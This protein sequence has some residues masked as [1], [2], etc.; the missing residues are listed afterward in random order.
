M[1]DL[2]GFL[3]NEDLTDPTWKQALKVVHNNLPRPSIIWRLIQS[4]WSG[5]LAS[6]SEFMK[7]L[8][9]SAL[10]M[11]ALLRA[12]E[13]EQPD[14][15]AVAEDV[16]QAVNFLGP[17]YAVIVLAINHT[18]MSILHSK[19][20]PVWR[21]VFRDMMTDVELGYKLGARTSELGLESGMLIGFAH[22]AGL[23]LLLANDAKGFKK[24]HSMTGG[25]QNR[26]LALKIFGCE[27]YQVSAF[28]VQHLGFGTDVALGTAVGTGGLNPSFL[29]LDREVLK[30]KAAFQWI[31]ALKEG[32]GFPRDMEMRTYF[33]E[34]IPPK[35][36][37]DKNTALEVLYTEV[38]KLRREGSS[39]MWH[40]PVPDYEETMR[41]LKL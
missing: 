8:S 28:L 35:S 11:R 4:S 22:G 32:R 37:D 19:P 40:L 38:A 24:W 33:S 30:W 26:D 13:L 9:C 17:R 16:Q 15:Q 20:P 18:C 14:T 2:E 1:L 41:I 6:Q 34:L 36:R 12:A 25:Y 23:G 39:W 31:E 27:P 21:R 10:N 3:E 29:N 5:T 7:I